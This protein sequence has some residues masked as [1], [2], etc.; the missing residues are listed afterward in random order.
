MRVFITQKEIMNKAEKALSAALLVGALA[1]AGC[2]SRFSADEKQTIEWA[3]KFNTCV[4]QDNPVVAMPEKQAKA[5]EKA[6]A[7]IQEYFNAM[8]ISA[9]PERMDKLAVKAA[10]AILQ[11]EVCAESLPIRIEDIQAK[12]NAMAEKYGDEKVR[13]AINAPKP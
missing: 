9:S 6:K 1:G 7:S 2:V 11:E 8:G 10:K 5:M 3:Q 13:K 12:L 4:Q